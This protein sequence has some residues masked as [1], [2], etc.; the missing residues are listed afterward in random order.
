MASIS[1]IAMWFSKNGGNVEIVWLGWEISTSISFF[2]LTT[3]ILFFVFF[4][5]FLFL[6][7]IIL[8]P[9]KIRENIKQYKI[10]NAKIALEEGLLA[11]AFE[12]KEKVLK[13]YSKAKK[14]LNETPLYLLLELQ[15]YLIKGNEAQCFN[16]YK[17]ML[18]FPASRPLAVKG[19]ILI[20]NKNSDTELF[21]NM[22]NS[23]K[24]FKVPLELF[25]ID[26]VKFCIKNS[27]WSL[28]KK[29]TNETT[30]KYTA[31]IK[32]AIS[33]LNFN[34]AKKNI[35]EGN[36]EKAKLILE[37]IFSSKIYYPDYIDMYCNLNLQKNDKELKRILKSYWKIF[38]HTNILDCV[39]KNFSNLN[40]S[41]KVKLLITL[42][43]GHNDHYLKY[44][45]LAEIKAKA[46]IW[47][48]SK[49]D[50]LKSIELYP[51]KKAYLLLAHIEE[52]TS[53]NKN[54]VKKW[55]DLANDC[56]EKQWKCQYCSFKLKNWSF[57]CENCNNLLSYINQGNNY[58]KKNNKELLSNN[59]SLKIA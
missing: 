59:N 48:D 55:L 2:L 22:L 32:H 21:S 49:K 43:E 16:T 41:E 51:S 50:L 38:P 36:P 39:L 8:L 28:L 7:K 26:A 47:G 52:Q 4:L 34:I 15:N 56:E 45:L 23:A 29:H 25:I 14:Y 42:L 24:T 58:E 13:S 11:S 44:L 35:E 3:F 5:L 40:I 12:E 9:F 19:L 10:K 30:K 37:K 53:Y 17:R 31:N 46:K 33:F 20:A 1:S 27:S 6:K 54:E 18:D 57:F